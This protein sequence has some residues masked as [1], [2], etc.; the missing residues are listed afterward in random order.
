M[1]DIH[2]PQGENAALV[3]QSRSRRRRT[4]S[5]HVSAEEQDCLDK[6]A[7]A[8]LRSRGL[9]SWA[10]DTEETRKEEEDIVSSHVIKARE[11]APPNPSLLSRQPS[12]MV[13]G[14]ALTSPLPHLPLGPASS[15]GSRPASVASGPLHPAE[16]GHTVRHASSD[17]DDTCSPHASPLGSPTHSPARTRRAVACSIPFSN[18]A[19]FPLSS[20]VAPPAPSSHTS[21]GDVSAELHASARLSPRASHD[22]SHHRGVSFHAETHRDH[23]HHRGV[24]FDAE[25]HRGIRS[26]GVA[27]RFVVN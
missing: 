9:E 8:E 24:S 25:T 1:V 11:R 10:P 17:S 12:P 6:K 20:V 22:H 21:D 7:E 19:F 14:T 4:V 16:A 15:A 3:E 26:D 18:S 13:L 5:M 2:E 23:S 27:H